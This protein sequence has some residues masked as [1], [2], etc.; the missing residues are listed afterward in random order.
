MAIHPA[1]LPV[2]ELL[3]QCD[4]VRT[5]RGGPGGQHRNKV[6]TAVVLTHRPTG[7]T[8][9]A[10]ERRSQAEN[11]RVAVGRLRLRLAIEQRTRPASAGPSPLWQSRV[12]GR[13]ISVSPRHED[14]PALIAEALD[15]LE[16]SG[17]EMAPTA[18]ALGVTTS[19]LIK[20]FRQVPAAWEA[21]NRLRLA[22]GLP[23]LK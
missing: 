18:A 19:Q 8:A 3:R 12:R 22:R 4:T 5:R 17:W 20:L 2:Q 14:L 16:Q 9:E 6:E 11:Q 15:Q 23:S 7:L 1:A 21:I 10:A 13:Q